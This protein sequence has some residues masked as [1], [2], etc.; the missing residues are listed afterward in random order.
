MLAM[1]KSRRPN[2]ALGS[3]ASNQFPWVAT[4]VVGLVLAAQVLAEG[5]GY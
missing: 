4:A 1:S 5:T 2:G 3:Q